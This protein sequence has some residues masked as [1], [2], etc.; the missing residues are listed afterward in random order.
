M[1]RLFLNK[2]LFREEFIKAAIFD[3]KKLASISLLNKDQY[4]VCLFNSCKY[5]YELT[6][7]EF[8]NYV[9]GLNAKG[10]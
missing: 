9:I 3:Y 10:L 7:H 6:I 8:E 1:N 5:D 4:Y 2:S